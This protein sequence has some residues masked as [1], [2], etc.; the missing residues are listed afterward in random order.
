MSKDFKSIAVAEIGTSFVEVIASPTG[1]ATVV[2]SC[3]IANIT[4]SGVQVDVR[5]YDSANTAYVYL[6][7]NAPIP[8]GSSL[9]LIESSK[10]VLNS[11]DI[12]EIK[13]SAVD[14]LDVVV[15]CME[16]VNI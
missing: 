10:L 1:E 11:D 5:Y 16:D 13:S 8:T 3:N 9:Q 6:L 14:S 12:I 7:K 15:S 4:A 2:V